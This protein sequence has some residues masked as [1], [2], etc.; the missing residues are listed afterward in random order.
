MD[1][2]DVRLNAL[3]FVNAR[4]ISRR[5]RF[6][7]SKGW[8]SLHGAVRALIYDWSIIALAIGCMLATWLKED[9]SL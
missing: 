6:V 5:G 3:D 4:S 7:K 2:D 8:F 9:F 1:P